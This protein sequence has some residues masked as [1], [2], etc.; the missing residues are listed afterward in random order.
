M[1]PQ[2]GARRDPTTG[3][4]ALRYDM[5]ALLEVVRVVLLHA[6]A[7]VGISPLDVIQD[8]Y[9]AA[10]GSAGHPSSKR[11]WRV[12]AQLGTTWKKA[13]EI[14]MLDGGSYT[15]AVRALEW[16][17]RVAFEDVVVVLALRAIAARLGVRTLRR[18]DYTNELAELLR[19]ERARWLHG[20]GVAAAFPNATQV[21]H[22]VGWDAALA[23][24]GL[25]PRG[26]VP[27][28][29]GVP[30]I[31]VAEIFLEELGYLPASFK[32]LARYAAEKRVSLADPEGS[33]VLAPMFPVLR[34]RRLPKWTPAAPP[35]PGEPVPPWHVEPL[36]DPELAPRNAQRAWTLA[37][38]IESL[39]TAADE[40]EALAPGTKLTQATYRRHQKGR[41]DLAPMS[42]IASIAAEHGTSFSRLRDQ[43]VRW[44]SG[45]REG[46]PEFLIEARRADAE[47]ADIAAAE[48]AAAL[49]EHAEQQAWAREIHAL[50]DREQ[51]EL[52]TY[53][54]VKL[55]G[56]PKETTKQRLKRLAR[57]S[58][59]RIERVE[60]LTPKVYW[61]PARTSQTRRAP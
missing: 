1:A 43:V 14:A 44:R 45:P 59:E 50:F 12:A 7:L 41:R 2:P 6:A 15:S 29:K 33:R 19:E 17:E 9:D 18:D 53:A 46:E 40:I 13:K 34:E 37:R 49:T 22:Q 10:R 3:R 38:C 52:T 32:E 5:F 28:L 58:L 35:A 48:K 61:R 11:A 55:L 25:D 57:S 60:G 31:D 23:L 20:G 42:R 26:G 27:F 36:A 39:M 8:D 30:A 21:D 51:R 4:F 56:W 47:A 16:R 54:L 24:A